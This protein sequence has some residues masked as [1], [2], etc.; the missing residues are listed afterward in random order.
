MK[1]FGYFVTESSEHSAEYLP[2][3]I[4]NKYP[5]LIEKFNIPLDEYPRRYI[6]QIE[7]WKTLREDLVNN[8][9]IEHKRTHEYASY[10]I[11]AMERDV[12]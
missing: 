9:D 10:I 11:E 6:K 4:K 7:K 12:P 8:K 5:E 1:R 3:F 2:Y